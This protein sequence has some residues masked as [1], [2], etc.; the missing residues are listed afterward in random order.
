MKKRTGFVSNSSSSSFII[1]SDKKPEEIYVSVSVPL[2]SIYCS[3][4]SIFSEEDLKEQLCEDWSYETFEDFLEGEGNYGKEIFEKKLK[5][6]KEGKNL[7]VANC[8]NEE[9]GIEAAL[10]DAYA[11]DIKI[12]GGEIIEKSNE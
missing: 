10:Y 1:A 4:E 11:K 12:D 3:E 9:G 7:Y 8:S 2:S 5:Y 6:I